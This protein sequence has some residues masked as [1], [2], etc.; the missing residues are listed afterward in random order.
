MLLDNIKILDLNKILS[1]TSFVFVSVFLF[2]CSTTKKKEDVKGI[3]KLY[4]NTTARFNGFFNAEEL[5][6]QSMVSLREMHVDNYNSIL[7]VYDYVDVDNPQSIKADMDKAIEKVSVVAT[8]HD[9]SNFVDDCYLLIG[10]AQYLKQ[11]YI[12][13]EE[14][15]QYFEEVF[16][17]KNPYG[18]AYDSSSRKTSTGRKSKKEVKQERKQ[19]QKDREEEKKIKDKEREEEKKIRDQERKDKEKEKKELQKQREKEKKDR[20]KSSSRKKKSSRSSR[21]KKSREDREPRKTETKPVEGPA[22][23]NVI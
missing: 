22:E 17:P 6:D 21:G 12:A 20:A 2:A 18:R 8:I 13:A 5:M 11:D 16:D 9:V 23:K 15:F 14:T 1:Y 4:H 10:K 3:K 19:Q 7:D